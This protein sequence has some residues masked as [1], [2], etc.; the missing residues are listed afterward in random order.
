MFFLLVLIFYSG[1]SRQNSAFS[2]QIQDSNL[3]FIYKID[4][5]NSYYI[6]Y[7]KHSNNN[8]K[9]VSFKGGAYDCKNIIVNNS[10]KLK[11][12]SMFILNGT[13]IIQASS[14]YEL[15]GWKFD[16]S[17]TIDFESGTKWGLFFSDNIKG[18]CY[19]KDKQLFIRR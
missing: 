4:S 2:S 18:L 19:I 15:S 6:I 8:Y 1:C 9:I 16:D 11:L 7:A 17:T 13:S 10:Y 14:M 5:I 3:Y 12:H